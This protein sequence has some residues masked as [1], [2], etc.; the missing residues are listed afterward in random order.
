VNVL[1]PLDGASAPSHI[2]AFDYTYGT[3]VDAVSYTLQNITGA[4]LGSIGIVQNGTSGKLELWIGPGN[5]AQDFRRQKNALD[6][7]QYRDDASTG[8]ASAYRTGP[9]LGPSRPRVSHHHGLTLR[10]RGSGALALRAQTLDQAAEFVADPIT[11]GAAPGL[12][13]D[14]LVDLIAEDV[15]W[16]ITNG[17]VADAWFDVSKI[18]HYSTPW[19]SQR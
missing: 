6:T 7:F 13:Y 18:T 17:G 8:I 2:M 3:T 12:E 16:Y 11:L 15:S 1:V 9:S 5:A 19:T 4:A 14:R 10:A